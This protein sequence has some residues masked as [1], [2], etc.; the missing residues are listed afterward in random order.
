VL[1]AVQWRGRHD[2]AGGLDAA[3]AAASS[4][5]EHMRCARPDKVERGSP[6]R[7]GDG[8]ATAGGGVEDVIGVGWGSGDR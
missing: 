3:V 6:V 1:R 4:S 2:L 7:S 8:E 5:L